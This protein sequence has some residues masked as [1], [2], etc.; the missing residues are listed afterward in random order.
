[1]GNSESKKTANFIIIH[2]YCEKCN[3]ILGEISSKFKE[4]YSSMVCID[5]SKDMSEEELKN[6]SIFDDSKEVCDI[7]K[8]E[9]DDL[10]AY[11]IKGDPIESDEDLSFCSKNCWNHYITKESFKLDMSSLSKSGDVL[12]ILT[13]GN[14]NIRK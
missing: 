9:T 1:M 4:N 12:D 3:K 13:K 6:K 10:Y 14:P 5:C 11:I 8:S 2:V 7:C